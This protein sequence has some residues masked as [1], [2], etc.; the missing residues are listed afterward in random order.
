MAINLKHPKRDDNTANPVITAEPT[1]TQITDI[2]PVTQYDITLDKQQVIQSMDMQ[3]IDQLTSQISIDDMDSIVSFGSESAEAISKASDAVLS[4]MSLNQINESSEMLKALSKI[5]DQFNIDELKEPKGLQKLFNKAQAQVEKILKKY[6]TMGGEIDKI[7]VELRKFQEEIKQSNRK[8]STL[9][10]SNVE[11]YHELEKY[12]FAGDQG[13]KEIQDAITQTQAE[14]DATGNQELRFQLQS[15]QNALALLEQRVQDLRT[16]EIVAMESIPM[17]KTMEFS[18]YNLYR[19][20][21][22]AI[23]ITLPVFKQALAQAILLKRQKIQA[24]AM[25]ELDAKTNELL[26]RNAQNTVNQAKMT[27]R[28]ASGSS[29]QIET[30]ENAWKTI[31]TG[32]DEVQQI[33]ADAHKKREDDK[34]RLQAIKNDFNAKYHVPDKK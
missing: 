25:S 28:M 7:Y 23:I 4:N 30:L 2:Q 9:F 32:I 17:L 33:E 21:E 31:T 16:A 5:M 6:N 10:E 26:M 15:Y 12:I 29:I 14:L 11:F 20:M 18:N 24:D 1:A 8:L 34:I 22:S 13:C 3:E 19:K 27:A